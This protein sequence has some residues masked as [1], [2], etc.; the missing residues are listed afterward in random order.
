MKSMTS[1]WNG[2]VIAGAA[3]LLLTACGGGGGGG[4]DTDS[5]DPT[6]Y[7][8]PV[9]TAGSGLS[10][11]SRSLTGEQTE[12]SDLLDNLLDA[13]PHI[14]G[15]VAV[16]QLGRVAPE[17][18]V[19]A[20]GGVYTCPGGGTV[21]YTG[22]AGSPLNYVYAACAIDGYV[23]EGGATATLAAGGNAFTVVYSALAVTGPDSLAIVAVGSTECALNAGALGGCVARYPTGSLVPAENFVW[24]WDTTW[25]AGVANGTHQCGCVLTWNATYQDFG[26]ASGKAVIAGSNGTAYV[27]RLSA[28][29]FNVRTVIG[30]TTHGPWRVNRPL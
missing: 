19:A 2:R 29:A 26:S 23:F 11:P 1:R 13:I 20:S 5:F 9:D 6:E 22:G 27:D 18:G 30:S 25:A 3:T 17:A 7:P 28:T 8:T 10:A 24:G 4:G 15:A 16:Q 12:S 21:T 14:P